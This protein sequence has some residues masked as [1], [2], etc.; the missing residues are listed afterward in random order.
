MLEIDKILESNLEV[1]RVQLNYTRAERFEF[2]SVVGVEDLENGGHMMV[3]HNSSVF[4]EGLPSIK[5]LRTKIIITGEEND[6]G[7]FESYVAF[8]DIKKL[9]TEYSKKRTE[10]SEGI[11]MYE[12]GEDGNEVPSL[13]EINCLIEGE[14]V[15]IQI[16]PKLAFG[17]LGFDIQLKHKTNTLNSTGIPSRVILKAN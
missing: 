8:D 15:K 17:D 1:F 16:R 9:D 11:G 14:P 12:Y 13:Y 5:N 4:L 7:W 6:E 3:S 10:L 2:K